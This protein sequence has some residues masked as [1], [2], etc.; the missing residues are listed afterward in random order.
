MNFERL[1]FSSSTVRANTFEMKTLYI[2][3]LLAIGQLGYSQSKV[4]G[5]VEANDD[6]RNAPLPG[7][8]VFWKGTTD[9]T[10]T[11][12]N[13]QFEL[14][15][16][17]HSSDLVFSFVGYQSDTV[18]AQWNQPMRIVLNT[19]LQLDEV[20]VAQKNKGMYASKL[21]PFQTVSINQAE[22]CKA[23]CCN[24]AESFV[25]NPSVDVS[26]TDAVSGAKQIQMLGLAGVYS[27]LQTE[28]LPNLRGIATSY[29]LAFVPGPWMESIQVSKGAASVVNGYES[30]TG[31]VNV[32]YRKPSDPDAFFFN[33]YA[34]DE[35][36][37]EVN[38][39]ASSKVGEKWSQ[40]TML[41][42]R[43]YNSPKD[44]NMDGFMDDPLTQQINL[45]HRW[46]YNRHDGG[47]MRVGVQYIDES[48]IGGQMGYEDGMAHTTSNPYGVNID[49]KRM[50]AF[51]KNGYVLKGTNEASVAFLGNVSTHRL[52]SVYGLNG[53]NAD[54]SSMYA[55]LVYS[56]N[57]NS[58]PK[59]HI[60]T[61]LSFNGSWLDETLNQRQEDYSNLVPGAY[62]EYSF[63]PTE[64]ITWMMGMRADHHN[65]FGTFVTPRT[66]FRYN[67]S[68][69]LVM[70][71][72]AGKGYRHPAVWAENSNLLASARTL[73]VVS[74]RI[75]EEAWNYGASVGYHIPVGARE[76]EI[77]AEYFR[78]DF[79]N[80]MVADMETDGANIIVDE[81]DGKSYANSY[82]VDV[83]F[84]T[85]P[86]LDVTLA[87]RINDVKQTIGGQLVDKPLSSR[88]KGLLTLNYSDRL[89][90]WMFDFNTQ[91]VGDGR[92][93]QVPGVP[94]DY[95]TAERFDAYQILNA[96]VTR[97]F[98]NGSVYLGCE[99]ISD[100]TQMHPIVAA[101]DPYG[102]YFDATRVWGP[103]MGRMFYMGVRYAIGKE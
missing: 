50:T 21:T 12:A 14:E 60:T 42:G 81:M 26:Y 78:T 37:F 39:F 95:H 11:N 18:S 77:N 47:I 100:F 40:A 52:R 17:I 57:I 53:Y 83:R 66:H 89:K 1:L 92:I 80:Q 74:Y 24:L 67:P 8:N 28:N 91:F 23:A 51:F 54:E 30:L 102:P 88:Y 44:H 31:Q 48:R 20:V 93:P 98:R 36:K 61:G 5:F 71:A 85:L 33:A 25:T 7:V 84:E 29:G 45:M 35:K 65:Y 64:K 32:E 76:I 15:M 62:A 10:V 87:M 38:V 56:T 75:L 55:S 6:G 22:L 94:H 97:F 19:D 2:I 43:Y 3:V 34:A 96:Q 9:G 13:G 49:N 72:S 69:H 79:L 41:H 16:S 103:V 68:E 4:T 99:N 46:D 82:Q 27:F 90:K 101:A 59:H 86:R 63:K 73:S 58:T 70:R